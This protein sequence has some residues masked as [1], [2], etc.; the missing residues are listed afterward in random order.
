MPLTLSYQKF[1]HM[2]GNDLLGL[3][4]IMFMSRVTR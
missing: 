3:V 1:S 4:E 2:S